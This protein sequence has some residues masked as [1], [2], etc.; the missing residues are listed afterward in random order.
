MPGTLIISNINSFHSNT[1]KLPRI[2]LI[3]DFMKKNSKYNKSLIPIKTTDITNKIIENLRLFSCT[4]AIQN[5][6]HGIEKRLNEIVT[7][8]NQI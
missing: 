6:N 8:Q 1:K 2:I 3:M 4:G 7:Q 5:R